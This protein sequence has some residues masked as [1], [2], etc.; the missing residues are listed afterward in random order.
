MS[1]NTEAMN[2]WE[3]QA[4]VEAV[5]GVLCEELSED[6]LTDDQCWALAKKIVTRLEIPK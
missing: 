2:E 4:A 6:Q 1:A 5:F 3:T